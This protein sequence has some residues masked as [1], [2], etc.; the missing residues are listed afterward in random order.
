MVDEASGAGTPGR[1]GLGLIALRGEVADVL[2]SFTALDVALSLGDEGLQ[3]DRADFGAVLLFLRALLPVFIVFELAL[4]A[5][6]FFVEEIGE[7][8]EQI[9]EVG[10]EAGVLESP[11]KDVEQVRDGGLAAG[12]CRAGGEDRARR[13]RAGSRKAAGLRSRG[14]LR[15]FV[16]GFVKIG[17]DVVKSRHGVSSLSGEPPLAALMARL[18]PEA[19]AG[20]APRGEA[21]EA[22]AQRRTAQGRLFCFAMQSGPPI[23]GGR[24]GK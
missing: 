22:G 4:N 2:E 12:R 10:F 11:G 24:G 13:R 14:R 20:A 6:G 18:L 1:A 9:G 17:I 23:S 15:S 5:G 21:S 8:P 7:A 16:S 3:F 19:R